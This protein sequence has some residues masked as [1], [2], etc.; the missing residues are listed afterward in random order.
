MI[1]GTTIMITDTI[2]TIMAMI[3]AI[4]SGTVTSGCGW[5][6]TTINRHPS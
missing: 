2:T 3:T 6:A 5:T 4:G 1:T